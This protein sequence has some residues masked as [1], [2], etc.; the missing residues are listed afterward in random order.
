MGGLMGK[1]VATLEARRSSELG[2]L[3]TARGATVLAAPAVEEAPLDNDAAI[4]ADF[5]AFSA[6]P[7]AAFIL[8][9]GVGT[10]LLFAAAER[11]GRGPTLGRVLSET[12]LV[13]RGP[14][15]VAALR[16]ENVRA[17]RVAAEPYTSAEVLAQLAGLDLAGRTVAVQQHGGSSQDL[18]RELEARGAAVRS[19]TLYRWTLPRD[20]TPLAA[21]IVQLCAGQ[22]DVVAFTS[23]VQVTHLFQVAEALG[24]V[25]PLR[26]ALNDD[27]LVAAVGP[28][29]RAALEEHGVYVGLEPPHPKMGALVAALAA[30]FEAIDDRA[31]PAC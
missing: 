26:Q 24:Y 4:A 11:T 30:H 5:D 1:R 18:Y 8:L 13:A 15:P 23:Q 12:V 10:R 25:G 27:T 31:T 14:K 7:P 2:H 3:L 6:Q 22:I 28:V 21:C 9:T 29:C 16:A 20:T 17:D 19:L